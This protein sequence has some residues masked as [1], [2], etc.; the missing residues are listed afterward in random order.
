MGNEDSRTYFVLC[1]SGLQ[2]KDCVTEGSTGIQRVDKWGFEYWGLSLHLFRLIIDMRG[3][4]LKT[5]SFPHHHTLA[6]SSKPAKVGCLDRDTNGMWNVV[7]TDLLS[8]ALRYCD[9]T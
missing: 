2:T 5:A 7:T 3:C 6:S 4:W 9:T 8:I 1:Q